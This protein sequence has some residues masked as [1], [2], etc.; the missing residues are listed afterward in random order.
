MTID[1]P[2]PASTVIL[3]KI[4][5]KWPYKVLLVK[6]SEKAKFLP[7]AHVFPGGSIEKN[8]ANFGTFLAKDKKGIERISAFFLADK[9]IISQHISAAVR[10]T[11]EETGISI[12]PG[13]SQASKLTALIEDPASG[14]EPSLDNIWPISWWITPKGESRRFNTWFFLALIEEAALTYSKPIIN[15]RETYDQRWLSPKEALNSYAMGQIFL[16]PPTRAV[17]ERM[18]KTSS[19]LEFLSYVDCPLRPINPFF[20]DGPDQKKMLIIPG[21]PLHPDQIKP[22]L[23]LHTRYF[24]P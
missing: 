20:V 8:D 14:I 2:I 23:P 7:G 1:E 4:T 15:T 9:K 16:A 22:A 10:E 18:E 12:L 24:F 17:L 13:L 19:L 21:D 6:R 11:M 5:T 3:C